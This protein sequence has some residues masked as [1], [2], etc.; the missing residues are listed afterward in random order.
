[1]MSELT[2]SLILLIGGFGS[3]VFLWVGI[4]LLFVDRSEYKR[5][6]ERSPNLIKVLLGEVETN[7][8]DRRDH[9]V[10]AGLA[11]DEKNNEWI[12]Q[13]ALSKEAIDSMFNKEL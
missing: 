6:R 12:E 3:I 10:K 11:F 2:K 4:K 9:R 5:N 7:Y 13:G 8:D 1:M